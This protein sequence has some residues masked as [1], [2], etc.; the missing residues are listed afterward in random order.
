MQRRK[1]LVGMGSIAAGGA[2]VM[3]T[4]AMSSVAANRSAQFVIAP[5]SNSA[6]L[7]LD[8]PNTLENGEYAK[9]STEHGGDQLYLAFN[10]EADVTGD[11]LNANAEHWFDEVFR[12]TNHG[13]N[14]LQTYVDDD[15][16]VQM[17]GG[18][19]LSERVVFYEG[20]TSSNLSSGGIDGASPLEGFPTNGEGNFARDDDQSRTVY[21]TGSSGN[22]WSRSLAPGASVAVGVYVDTRGLHSVQNLNT[23]G[24]PIVVKGKEP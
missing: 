13:A 11:G 19:P 2:A 4:G 9:D 6:Y 1:F 21:G 15:T 5:D 14:T 12:I 17:V 22:G 7:K 20:D 3:G 10:D 18:K 16:L 23:N 24:D 8:A